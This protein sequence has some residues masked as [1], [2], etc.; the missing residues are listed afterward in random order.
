MS[1]ETRLPDF[2]VLMSLYRHDPEAFEEF[3]KHVLREAIDNAPPAHRPALE[4]VLSR[5]ETARLAAA[6][7]MEGALIAFRMMGESLGMLTS[8]WEEA[9][10]HAVAE[11]QT[12]LIIERLR[13]AARS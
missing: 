12:S 1:L 9:G 13:G 3:R 11:L 7:P 4:Q 8:A 10:R 6:T 2:D 5:I